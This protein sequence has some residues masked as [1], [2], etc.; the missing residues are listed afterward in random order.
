MY[1]SA[2]YPYQGFDNAAYGQ[3]STRGNRLR[4]RRAEPYSKA[5]TTSSD[6]DEKRK[7]L[8][9]ATG[10]K[11]TG[12]NTGTCTSPIC[13]LGYKH[14]KFSLGDKRRMLMANNGPRKL[15]DGW[16]SEVMAHGAELARKT[17]T[18]K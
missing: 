17:M 4:N 13:P 8:E 18:P 1:P 2:N 11:C 3:D 14:E 6:K 16:R 9:T 7:L 10:G 15:M 5:Q 12:F